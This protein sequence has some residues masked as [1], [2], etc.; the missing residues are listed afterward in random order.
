MDDR[1]GSKIRPSNPL[2]S[3]ISSAHRN[4]HVL[5][6]DEIHMRV[7]ARADSVR[8]VKGGMIAHIATIPKMRPVPP[9]VNILRFSIM[10]GARG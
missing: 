7:A 6:P 1:T 8:G 10:K 5:P 4:A 3:P 9:V 2:D